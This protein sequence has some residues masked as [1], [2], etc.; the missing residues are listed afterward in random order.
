MVRRSNTNG[1][2]ANDAN[3]NDASERTPSQIDEEDS[4][5]IFTPYHHSLLK[6]YLTP[7]VWARLSHRSTAHGTTLE[8]IIR[9]GVSL[10]IGANPPRRV[11]VLVGDADCYAVFRDLLE[12]II[13]EYHGIDSY[14]EWLDPELPH[15]RNFAEPDAAGA[16][17]CGGA[18]PPAG[19]DAHG[20]LKSRGG[21]E[22]ASDNDDAAFLLDE[23]GVE[24]VAPPSASPPQAAAPAADRHHLM[25]AA[26]RRTTLRRHSTMVN[27]PRLVSGRQVDPDARYIVSTRIRVARS[28]AGVEFPATMSRVERRRVQRLVGECTEQLQS[29]KLAAGSYLP[30]LAMTNEQ[31]LDLIQRHILFDNPN[32]WTI[33]SGLGRDWPDGRALYANVDDLDSQTPDFMIWVNEEDHLRIMCLRPGGDIQGVF[34]TLMDGVRELEVELQKRGWSFAKDTR[35]GYLTSCPTNIGTS[36]RASVHVRLTNLG[37]LPGFLRL[38]QRLKLEARGKYGETDR[39]HTGVF[40]ISNAERL[41]KSEVHLINVMVEGVAQLIEVEKRLEAGEVVN[42][43]EIARE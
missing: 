37:R 1:P 7:A 9:A 20:I 29:P 17:A 18:A 8:D 4:Y 23:D 24:D 27:N 34:T 22:D 42:I 12:P 10:P 36:M 3:N 11:G 31:N 19:E 14:E 2:G 16:A 38:V 26:K 25:I 15:A 5:P 28:L 6:K 43:E 41:G 13:R 32:E 35:L 39:Q 33:A 40:D 30:V 21:D